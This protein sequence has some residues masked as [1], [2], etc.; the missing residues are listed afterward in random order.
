M[1]IDIPRWGIR[2]NIVKEI[3]SAA[4]EDG[5][6]S[7]GRRAIARRARC[8]ER[9]VADLLGPKGPLW[10]IERVIHRE[11]G[12]GTRPTRWRL[13]PNVAQWRGVP[14]TVAD[15]DER[16][17][18]LIE[19]DLNAR[20]ALVARQLAPLAE[21]AGA[22]GRATS[23]ELTSPLRG[24]AAEFDGASG[25]ADRAARALSGALFAPQATPQWRDEMALAARPIAPQANGSG[26]PLSMPL[27][28]SRERERESAN[29]D[30]AAAVLDA[31]AEATGTR[32][33]GPIAAQLID[34][35]AG[36]EE[37]GWIVAQVLRPRRVKMGT[38]ECAEWVRALVAHG[39]PTAAPPIRTCPICG[40][41]TLAG[42]DFCPDAPDCLPPT[43]QG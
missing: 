6:A 7:I 28:F 14:W 39:P 13:N 5:W 29:E 37:V 36:V 35:L 30:Q 31:I 2:Y 34:S 32:P 21:I 10:Y 27:G 25:A 42:A 11:P 17:R 18:R 16:A 1:L 26:A 20:F 12:S 15:P 24:L 40:N 33:F 9:Y 4:G 8:S 43:V 3:L 41:A 22:A 19:A 38:I 23:G